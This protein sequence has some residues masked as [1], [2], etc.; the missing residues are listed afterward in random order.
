MGLTDIACRVR[1]LMHPTLASV[2]A[3]L[4]I[5]C[6]CLS[7]EFPPTVGCERLSATYAII[8]VVDDR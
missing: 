2:N 6:D 5:G 4:S 1:V 3:P 8:D 7:G